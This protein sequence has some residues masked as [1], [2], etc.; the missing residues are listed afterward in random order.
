MTR[1]SVPRR[2]VAAFPKVAEHLEWVDVLRIRDRFDPLAAKI[3]AHVTLVSPFEDPVSDGALHAH[4]RAAVSS[5]A[6]FPVT[7]GLVTIH[8]DEFLFLNVKRG[9]DQIVH[10]RD[11]LYSGALARHLVRRQT[12]VP[13]ITVGRVAPDELPAALERTSSLTTLIQAGIHTVSVYR[14]EPDGSRPIL[15]EVPLL[16]VDAR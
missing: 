8:D 3:A 15:F 2:V 4:V 10:L 7:F 1:A 6:R 12:F 5:I 14:I 13:H 16:T 11:A 9:N